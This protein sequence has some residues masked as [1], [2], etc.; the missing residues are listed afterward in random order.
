[1][2]VVLE[3]YLRRI[4]HKRKFLIGF[5][6]SLESLEKY[7]KEMKHLLLQSPPSQNGTSSYYSSLSLPPGV[8]TGPSLIDPNPQSSDHE[9]NGT[10]PS[11]AP[12]NNPSTRATAANNAAANKRRR[13]ANRR[14]EDDGPPNKKMN[15]GSP[16]GG[17]NEPMSS[18]YFSPHN[19]EYFDG[20]AIKDE[21]N[22]VNNEFNDWMEDVGHD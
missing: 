11:N 20:S 21:K 17:A 10:S 14:G 3:D 19:G 13:S 1:M 22:D 16:S 2:E 5:F 8:S 15:K 9:A 12:N 6:T 4:F 7:H 18:P